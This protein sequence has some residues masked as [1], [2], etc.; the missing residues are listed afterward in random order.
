MYLN[1]GE[2]GG[3]MPQITGDTELG[4]S[5]DVCPLSRREATRRVSPLKATGPELVFVLLSF[6]LDNN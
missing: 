5:N 4:G 3:Q 2:F 1:E 6:V